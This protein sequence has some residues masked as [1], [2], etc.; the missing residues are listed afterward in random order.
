MF[1]NLTWLVIHRGNPRELEV[2]ACLLACSIQVLAS[3]FL[4]LSWSPL[5]LLGL[6]QEV[7]YVSDYTRLPFHCMPLWI[8]PKLQTLEFASFI[9]VSPFPSSVFFHDFNKY[10]PNKNIWLISV[11]N[12]YERKGRTW[13][14]YSALADPLYTVY[15]F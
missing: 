3:I 9:A 7:I 11:Q 8:V 5:S 4:P 12:T 2:L 1:K 6:L 13:R 15:Q 10:F 14:T